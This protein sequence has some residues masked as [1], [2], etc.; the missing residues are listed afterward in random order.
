[1]LF[2]LLM[3]FIIS[4]IVTIAAVFIALAV[5]YWRITLLF[6]IVY[7]EIRLIRAAFRKK[8]WIRFL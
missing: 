8:Q 2:I 6:L 3:L 5:Y 7:F 4:L 1:V